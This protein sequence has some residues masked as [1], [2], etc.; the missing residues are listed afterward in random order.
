MQFCTY[1]GSDNLGIGICPQSEKSENGS[2]VVRRLH[3]FDMLL[4]AATDAEQVDRGLVVA[5]V[6]LVKECGL[7]GGCQTRTTLLET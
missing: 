1:T 2:D 5:V 6:I 7:S 4:D 3:R